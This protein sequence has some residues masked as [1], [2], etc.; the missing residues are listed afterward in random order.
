MPTF[1]KLDQLT[2]HPAY[3]SL[4][5]S[6]LSRVKDAP[7]RF[8]YFDK[9]KFG[10]KTLPLVLVDADAALV[11]E[12][13]KKTNATAVG[14]CRLNEQ[15]QLV[16]EPESGRLNR[17]ALKK[18]LSSFSGVKTVWVPAAE[19]ETDEKEEEPQAPQ[20]PSERVNQAGGAATAKAPT[21]AEL[22]ATFNR[23]LPIAKQAATDYPAHKTRI[24]EA[25]MAAQTLIKEGSLA[26][27]EKA[28]EKATALLETVKKETKGGT[29]S[30]QPAGDKNG[31]M[32]AWQT[33][34]GQVIAS[35]KEL[36]NKI[37]AMAD[38]EGDAAIVLVK[39]IQANLT[40]NP[41][42]PRQIAELESYLKTD[43]VIKDAEAENGFGITIDISKPLLAA[44]AKLKP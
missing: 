5:K 14:K 31:A 20:T 10:D 4:L 19:Q 7:V 13:K 33:A 36:E 25:V 9:F 6:A 42:T 32:A 24:T 26:E 38:P 35:L 8:T 17:S 22:T 15:D 43:A 16:F 23:L 21:V 2:N 37:S 39:S 30:S 11:N 41:V 12:V 40:A 29:P 34:R 3:K 44:L 27:A 18:Y 1:T 28:L